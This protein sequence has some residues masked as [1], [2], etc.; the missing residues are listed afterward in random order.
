MYCRS[1]YTSINYAAAHSVR[2]NRNGVIFVSAPNNSSSC[3][4]LNKETRTSRFFLG[5]LLLQSTYPD[6]YNADVRYLYAL[7]CSGSL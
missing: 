7:I 1:G 4:H 2:N 6:Y 5:H 3:Y